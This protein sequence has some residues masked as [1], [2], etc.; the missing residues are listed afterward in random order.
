MADV[1][2]AVLLNIRF[3]QAGRT[4]ARQKVPVQKQAVDPGRNDDIAMFIAFSLG[5]VPPHKGRG[6][7]ASAA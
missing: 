5:Q 2:G 3:L 7:T 6:Q 1:P 4:G